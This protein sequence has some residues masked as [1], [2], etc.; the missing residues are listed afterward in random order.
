MYFVGIFTSEKSK[1]YLNKIINNQIKSDEFQII[2]LTEK[3]IENMKNVHFDSIVVNKKIINS[4]VLKGNL[5]NTKF[6]IVNTD[7][8]T[9]LKFLD[10]TNCS[11]ITY[12]FNPKSTV[13]F[14]SNTQDKIQICIQ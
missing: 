7:I 10:K 12:G 11:V 1:K 4:D 8:I 9:N 3:S 13:T 5:V 2:Y 14:S 6:V